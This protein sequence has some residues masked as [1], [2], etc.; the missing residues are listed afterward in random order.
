MLIWHVNNGLI[1]AKMLQNENVLGN[2]KR[3]LQAGNELKMCIISTIN[4]PLNSQKSS[5]LYVL[6]TLYNNQLYF[7]HNT[8][9]SHESTTT[10]D[11]NN[12][13]H[14]LIWH[15]R[16]RVYILHDDTTTLLFR[17][18]LCVALPVWF[19]WVVGELW[20]IKSVLGL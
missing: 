9:T 18:W 20:C 8:Q 3:E 7:L 17:C 14:F 2:I 15:L 1:V 16:Y 19:V 4:F 6:Y 5:L 12:I 10:I 13:T 11:C